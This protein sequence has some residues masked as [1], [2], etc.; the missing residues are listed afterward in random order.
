VDIAI[1]TFSPP[2][3]AVAESD[4]LPRIVVAVEIEAY[5]NRE[6]E[7]GLSRR[8]HTVDM[9]GKLDVIPYE[10]LLVDWRYNPTTEL[11]TDA[12]GVTLSDDTE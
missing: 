2:F 8:A 4:S 6:G 9:D 1:A 5:T 10:D 7:T 3:K 11:W 12:S